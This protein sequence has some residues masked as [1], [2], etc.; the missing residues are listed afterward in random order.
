MKKSRMM[1]LAL[2]LG[3]AVGGAALTAGCDDE[4]PAERTGEKL[5][6]LGEKIEDKVDPKGPLE[7]AGDKIDEAV[8]DID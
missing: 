3:L 5:E 7:K 8:D 6:R 1:S 2:A 4:G